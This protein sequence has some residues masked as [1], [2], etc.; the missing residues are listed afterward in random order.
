MELNNKDNE[1][2]QEA[3][4][5][6]RLAVQ[7]ER[8]D[9]LFYDYLI[10][11][12]PSMESSTNNNMEDT[13]NNTMGDFVNTNMV[14]VINNGMGAPQN[15][16]EGNNTSIKNT[17]IYIPHP[18]NLEPLYYFNKTFILIYILFNFCVF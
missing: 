11:E 17:Y 15:N 10:E 7:G 2:L 4:K 16:T 1:G 6:V 5:G 8:E 3:I 13:Q 14:N 12:A 18:K 9:E